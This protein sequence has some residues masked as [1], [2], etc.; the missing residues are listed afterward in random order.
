MS[1]SHVNYL[2]DLL[3]RCGDH[4]HK[5]KCILATADERIRSSVHT[6]V[7]TATACNQICLGCTCGLSKALRSLPDV[8]VRMI[9][10][11]DEHP[12]YIKIEI[13]RSDV[14]HVYRVCLYDSGEILVE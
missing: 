5:C 14:Q 3:R 1:Q 13:V 6:A 2:R 8:S 4:E 12:S 10:R 11:D 7:A 9:S